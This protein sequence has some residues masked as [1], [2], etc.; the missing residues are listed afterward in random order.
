MPLYVFS[1]SRMIASFIEVR[2]RLRVRSSLAD[3]IKHAISILTCIPMSQEWLRK[4]STKGIVAGAVSRVGSSVYRSFYIYFE[5]QVTSLCLYF[6]PMLATSLRSSVLLF[7]SA[8]TF[9]EITIL[10]LSSGKNQRKA[11]SWHL[12]MPLPTMV[13]NQLEVTP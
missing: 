3:F 13:Q 4:V 6:K 5:G 8:S 11:P 9:L 10:L 1:S 7:S 12:S 2:K